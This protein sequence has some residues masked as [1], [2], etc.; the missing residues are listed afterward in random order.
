MEQLIK[1]LETHRMT[2]AFKRYT[3]Y[4]CPGCGIQ[5]AFIELLKGHIGESIR[6]YPALIPMIVTLLFILVATTGK[7]PRSDSILKFL[8][9]FT[10]SILIAG[11]IIKLL[12]A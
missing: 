11:Y 4:D 12:T 8:I 3:G 6:L 10:L 5:S 1:W 9:I 7:V 2:C